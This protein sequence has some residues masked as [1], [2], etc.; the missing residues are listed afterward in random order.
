[1]F[2]SSSSFYFEKLCKFSFVIAALLG[3]GVLTES[4]S[5]ALA[6]MQE[7]AKDTAKPSADPKAEQ[8]W[9]AARTGNLEAINKALDEG[10]DVNSATHYNSTALTFACD[11]GQIEAIK[12]LLKRG[13]D[14]NLE[15]TFY[16]ASPLDW[17]QMNG[18][19]E[20]VS[21][22][23]GG[24]AKGADRLL[25]DGIGS[26]DKKLVEAV[27]NSG[28]ASDKTIAEGKLQ[29]SALKLEDLLPL[30]D[31]L[32]FEALPAYAPSKELLESIAGKYSTPS[33]PVTM[34]MSVEEGQLSMEFGGQSMK[35]V[36][37]SENLFAS[38]GTRVTVK[39]EE[40]KVT[41]LTRSAGENSIAFKPG[42]APEA[43]ATP[44]T[45]PG[46][47][48]AAEEESTEPAPFEPSSADAAVSSVNWP[49]FRGVGSRGVAD[50]QSPPIQWDAES[51]KNLAW[52]KEIPGLGNSCPVIWGDRLYITSAASEK[53]DKDVKIGLY[54]DVAS[55]VDDSTY[56]FV[57]FCL[58]K[59]T[60]EQLWRQV[61]HTGKPAVKR[62]SKSSH[63]NSTVATDGKHVLAF[64]GTEGLYCYD[65][66][67]K[68]LWKR[69]LG[70]LDSGWFFNADYQWGFGSSPIIF[71]DRVI[72]Q[73]DIQKESFVAALD[74]S[75]GEEVWR[76][77]RDEIPGWSSPVVHQFG[78]IPMLITHGTRAARGYDARD[79]QLL[80]SIP[81]HSEIVV[82]TPF[83]AHDLIFVSSGYTPV[84]PIVAIR[85][86]AR[87]ELKLPGKSKD[88]STE[89]TSGTANNAN[90]GIAWSHLR[91]GP[92]MPT[93][94]AYGDFLYTC[95][96]NGVLTC[97]RATTG[98]QVYKKRLPGSGSLSFTGSPI[99]ADGHLYLPAEDGQVYVVRAG[100]KFKLVATNQSGG[101]VLTTPAISQGFFYI[102]TTDSLFAFKRE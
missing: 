25:L 81:D 61:A 44:A 56:E 3:V 74:I 9:A 80:W 99:A 96:N 36:P 2:Q 88:D 30:F 59:N 63:A 29:A 46:K 21:L 84:Q 35:L 12:L 102:R 41:E 18:H 27:L 85:P 24:G 42:A 62:H 1:M 52:K 39:L 37:I 17:A 8:L 51:G 91:G 76:T 87:G 34:T 82:P 15:D 79:G 65:N 19:Y 92:Y 22:V 7:P 94:I 38:G 60:G 16:K 97:Y 50:G 93:P 73:C 78:D 101:K 48:E 33:I 64:F 71:G 75:T 43:P 55:V 26:R 6:A 95:A 53:G 70:F 68:L 4:R 31:S 77:Q 83:V 90:A 72:V 13:A 14:P 49:S 69:D 23:L 54:G 11:R 20:A 67:G 86:T 89:V 57:V 100:D 45:T 47:T 40:G 66:N 10:V 32:K 5:S 28:K 58:D 98:E